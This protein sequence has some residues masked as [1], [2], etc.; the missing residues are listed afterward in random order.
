MPWSVK[1][2][3]LKALKKY[4]LIGTHLKTKAS[5]LVYNQAQSNRT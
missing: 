2:A 1:Y 5:K 3:Y 4:T